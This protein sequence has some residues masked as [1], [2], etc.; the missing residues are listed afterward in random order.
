MAKVTLNLAC[1]TSDIVA[2]LAFVEKETGWWPNDRRDPLYADLQALLDA[3]NALSVD[4]DIDHQTIFGAVSADF[5]QV[6]AKHGLA[7]PAIPKGGA[8]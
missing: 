5:L 3:G 8:Q 6:L 7:V 1:D 2:A 4:V